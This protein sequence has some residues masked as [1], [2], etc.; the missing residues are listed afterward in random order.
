VTWSSSNTALAQISNDL[1]NP[2]LSLAVSNPASGTNVTITAKVG[3]TGACTSPGVVC[4]TATLTVRPT[5]FVP[6]SYPNGVP[7]EMTVPR[8]GHT[9]TLLN[10]GMVLIAGGVVAGPGTVA[11][12]Y[13]PATEIFTQTGSMHATRDYST[14]T[15]LQDGTVLIV[16]G[17][18]AGVVVTSAEIYDPATGTF[19]LT[20]GSLNT[21]RWLH[22]ATLLPNG[23]V[24]IAGGFNHTDGI[25]MS[26][27]LYDPAT[28]TFSYTTDGPSQGLVTGREQHTATLLNNGTVLIAGGYGCTGASCTPTYLS[29]AELYNPATG[30]FTLTGMMN[31]SRELH[32]AT[33]LNN[34]SVL[35]AGGTADGTTPL[36]SAEVYNPA[37]G[38]F[39]YTRGGPSQ[40]LNQ[41]RYWHTATLLNNG[42]VLVAGG[43]CDQNGLPLVSAEL[44]NLAPT[45]FSY[46]AGGPDFGLVLGVY[47]HQATLLNNGLVL[48]TGGEA[49]NG[50]GLG[51]SVVADLY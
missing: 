38:L 29:S 47:E 43:C 33:L 45:T 2:G 34:G 18:F 3:G 48:I 50:L 19:S 40:G 25:L 1:T 10:N 28:G 37:T 42:L 17:E 11:E 21:P 8:E 16:G 27:E 31:A 14:A 32:T 30:T 24:L 20:T 44:F 9:A 51:P 6:T 22:T 15:L 41:A 46:T 13:N 7:S 4:G 5:G 23:Q 35:I 36:P 49:F 12:L 39:T 26:A